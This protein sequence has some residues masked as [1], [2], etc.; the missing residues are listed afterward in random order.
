[1]TKNVIDLVHTLANNDN[2]TNGL[3]IETKTSHILYDSSWI[4]GVDY[5]SHGD[6]EDHDNNTN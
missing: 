5:D 3:K 6:D 2:M 4:A 1:M